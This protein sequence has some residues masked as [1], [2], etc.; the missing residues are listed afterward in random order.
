M[1]VKSTMREPYYNHHPMEDIE[2]ETPVENPTR[3]AGLAFIRIISLA[4]AYIAAADEP[5][6]ATYGVAYAL[7]LSSITEG[8]S[9]RKLGRELNLS[10][11]TISFHARNFVEIANLPPSLQMR[12][13]DEVEAAR[14]RRDDFCQ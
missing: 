14:Q 12:N 1:L 8:K 13:E 6:T 11:G 4:L 9:M 5:L 2:P 3:A 10:H 7:G